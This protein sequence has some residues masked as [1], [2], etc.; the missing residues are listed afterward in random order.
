MDWGV[1]TSKLSI[2]LKISKIY[3]IFFDYQIRSSGNVSSFDKNL[4]SRKKT[5]KNVVHTWFR[6]KFICIKKTF[7]IRR[8]NRFGCGI[9]ALFEKYA[10]VLQLDTVDLN[11]DGTCKRVRQELAIITKKQVLLILHVCLTFHHFKQNLLRSCHDD[12]NNNKCKYLFDRC[13]YDNNVQF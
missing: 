13:L 12:D 3:M 6:M 8:L 5:H 11:R 9:C 2:L 7:I 4:F 1:F 10:Y